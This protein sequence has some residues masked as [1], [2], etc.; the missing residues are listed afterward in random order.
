MVRRFFCVMKIFALAVVACAMLSACGDKE[1]AV[2]PG[3]VSSEAFIFESSSSAVFFEPFSSSVILNFASSSSNDF[4]LVE[5]SGSVLESSSSDSIFTSSSSAL[6]DFVDESSSSNKDVELIESSSNGSEQV[7]SSNSII[8]SSSGVL[9]SSCSAF[10]ELSSSSFEPRPPRP[11][12][13]KILGADISKFQ[14]YEA[15][16]VRIFDVDGAE[17]DIFNLL[18]DHGFNAVR[19][20]TFVSPKAQYGYAASGCGQDLEAFA[21]KEHVVAYAQKVK[22]AGMLF[23]LDIHYSDNWADPA[24]QIIPE[25]WRGVRSSDAMADSVYAYTYDLLMALKNVGALPDMV[26]VGNEITN[27]MLRDLPTSN[28][29]CWGDNV[30][31]AD[32]AV[33][34]VMNK[35]ENPNGISN[36]AKY[37]AAGSRAVKEFETVSNKIK[38][39]FHI[40]SPQNETTVN[41]WMNSILKESKVVPDV[42]AFSAYT[43]YE[44]GTPETWKSLFTKLASQYSNVEFLIA[45]YNGSV[46]KQNSQEVYYPFDG[47]RARTHQIMEQVPRGL[48]AF[49]WEPAYS[50]AWGVALFDWDDKNLRANPKAFEEYKILFR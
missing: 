23:L 16:D 46:K 5:S 2:Y 27:G 50:G 4:E 17:K 26:Q 18:K 13:N 12:Y 40:E 31:L 42:M 3:E 34:G 22:A 28:T 19:L 38:T 32:N 43:A 6:S 7:E 33:N 44:H 25:C 41:W 49:F 9:E 48:G 29:N 24:K 36:T 45:E 30:K 11:Q 37:L 47:A 20:K 8:E 35:R 1:N 10:E 21:D 39:V 15:Y 14:E